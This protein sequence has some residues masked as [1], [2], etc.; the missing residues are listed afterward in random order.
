MPTT[1]CLRTGRV[2]Y[3]DWYVEGFA[4]YLST[5]DF[6]DKGVYIGKMTPYRAA[7][8]AAGDWISI[9]RFLAKWPTSMSGMDANQY[10]SQ[11]WLTT[12]YLFTTPERAPGFDRHI[13]A[14]QKGG[15]VIGAFE[16]AFGIS[17]EAFDKELRKYRNSGI[18]F[19]LVPGVIADASVDMKVEQLDRA[20]DDL[21]M[22]S[23]HLRSGPSV[24]SAAKSVAT[25]RAQAK[26][27][28][29]NAYALRSLALAEVWYGDLPAARTLLDGLLASDAKDAELNHLSGLCDLRTFYKVAE[30]AREVALARMA[31]D[32]FANADALDGS[33]PASLF[34]YLEASLAAGD[35]LDDRLLPVSLLAY[36]MSP[37]VGPMAMVAARALML[38]GKFDEAAIV[39]QPL[40]VS[41]H[42]EEFAKI[43]R[44]LLAE[45]QG[46]RPAEQVFYGSVLEPEKAADDE[47]DKG[48]KRD[49]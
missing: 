24:K 2:T 25:I 28:P 17:T 8:A 32:S 34:R 31:R 11:A 44:A 12:H 21:M 6:T 30:G 45:A 4:E 13:S 35:E 20:A 3:P 27:Y 42:G 18:E 41:V 19:R 39:L 36:Q 16:P 26:K 7:F 15:D 5:A 22:P 49:E 43:A 9:D 48:D 46:K 1:T 37:Q 14:L 47:K 38:H 33:P 10:C 29:D 40:T 23:A